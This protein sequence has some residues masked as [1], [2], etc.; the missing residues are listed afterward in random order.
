M[1]TITLTDEQISS[2]KSQ[3]NV[4]S[5]ATPVPQPA[6]TPSNIDL[7]GY[8]Q[9]W[10]DWV[11]IFPAPGMGSQRQYTSGVRTDD[12]IVIKFNAPEAANYLGIT[13]TFQGGQRFVEWSLSTKPGDFVSPLFGGSN[14]IQPNINFATNLSST[15]TRKKIDLS[16]T[17]NPL[18][19]NI[20]FMDRNI[21][22][23][24]DLVI[25]FQRPS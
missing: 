14:V 24:S 19:F 11:G 5:T 1:V 25:L 15:D 3:L 12:L 8:R 7:S 4:S 18:Y 23:S 13:T 10:Y 20:R 6:S 21:S 9:V 22:E 2:I 17:P 16:K